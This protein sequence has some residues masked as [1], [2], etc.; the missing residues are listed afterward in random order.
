MTREQWTDPR[1]TFDPHIGED[2]VTRAELSDVFVTKI[3]RPNISFD[4]EKAGNLH[5]NGVTDQLAHV[6]HNGTVVHSRRYM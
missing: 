2:F 3:W 6:Y 5:N 4:N 1:L